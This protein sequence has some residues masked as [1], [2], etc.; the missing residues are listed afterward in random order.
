MSFAGTPLSQGRRL[1]HSAFLGKP[2]STGSLPPSYSYGSVPFPFPDLSRSDKII[3]VRSAPALGSRSPPKDPSPSR[4][5]NR[6]KDHDENEDDEPALSRFA[7]IKQRESAKDLS[8]RPGGPKIIT[9]PPK[10]DKWSVKDTSVNIA[11]AFTQAAAGEN[12][13]TTYNP[14]N[15]WASTSR[16]S[17]PVPRSTSVE[18]EAA[19]PQASNRRLPPPPDKF[20]RSA[21]AAR[22]PISKTSSLR[23]VPDSEGEEEQSN[24]NVRGKSPFEQGVSFA[25]QALSVATYYVR[26]RSREPENLSVE[27]P[28][29]SINGGANGNDSS[30]DY[31]AEEQAFQSQKRSSAAARRSRMS[32]D[33]KAYKPPQETEDDES[34][35]SDGGKTRRRKRKL[36]KGS[37]G[38]PLSTLPVVSADKR[39][40]RKSHGSKGNILGDEEESES[41]DNAQAD[42]VSFHIL[43]CI[44]DELFEIRRNQI[45]CV[46]RFQNLVF[47][48]HD[49]HKNHHS[50]TWMTQCYLPNKDYNPSLKLMRIACRPQSPS[51]PH[52]NIMS[53]LNVV[54]QVRGLAHGHE[55]LLPT[56]RFQDFPLEVCWAV[57]SIFPSNS[58][59]GS[60]QEYCHSLACS[61][62]CAD[63][64][65]GRHTT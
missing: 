49:Y 23:H 31:A 47:Y 30:Y 36:K 22:K 52:S 46:H 15:A 62:L 4:D 40:R 26:Q 48:P 2:P 1:D 34:E 44:S 29:P 57:S 64:S 10:P 14:N 19:A 55:H 63:K 42:M 54:E 27:R 43:Y 20:H 65:L 39:R 61:A 37:A 33:N 16:A 60:S 3:P 59:Y 38:G 45:T 18:Y 51:P 13:S 24:V 32:V 28:Q 8:N 12:M 21:V 53:P 5:S 58:L 56:V 6:N 41:E 17:L 11:T 35:W 7:R 50:M 25:K 9:S